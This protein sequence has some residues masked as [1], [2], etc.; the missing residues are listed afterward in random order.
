MKRAN[1]VILAVAAIVGLFVSGLTEPS[2]NQ[3]AMA[4]SEQPT[5]VGELNAGAANFVDSW[6]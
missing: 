5:L 3:Q 6:Q 4:A 2:A 1:S